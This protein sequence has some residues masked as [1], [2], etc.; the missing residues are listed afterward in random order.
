MAFISGMQG[1][2]NIGKVISVMLCINRMKKKNHMIF[3]IDP[4]IKSILKS[5]HPFMIRIQNT[6]QTILNKSISP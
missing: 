1:W 2:I 5:H 4:E 3:T 6:Q